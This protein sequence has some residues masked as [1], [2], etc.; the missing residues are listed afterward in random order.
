MFTVSENGNKIQVPGEAHHF[1][2]R[3]ELRFVSTS[4]EFDR[5]D[6]VSLAVMQALAVR[7]PVHY[8]RTGVI[9]REPTARD[10]PFGTATGK[11][12]YIQF[13]LPVFVGSVDQPLVVRR[14]LGV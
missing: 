4:A 10:L 12:G 9:E 14:Q 5:V 7:R 11:R 1:L 2:G 3:C 8:S 6:L 13:Y